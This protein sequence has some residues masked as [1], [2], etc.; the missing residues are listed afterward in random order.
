[1]QSLPSGRYTSAKLK[2][3]LVPPQ[4][5]QHQSAFRFLSLFSSIFRNKNF[6]ALS[7][8]PSVKFWRVAHAKGNGKVEQ[9]SVNRA[10]EKG[11]CKLVASGNAGSRFEKGEDT[12]KHENGQCRLT[13]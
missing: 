4:L 2:C 8:K 5:H 11:K 3:Q 6:L 12:E 7:L 1:M 9:V 13:D 10:V